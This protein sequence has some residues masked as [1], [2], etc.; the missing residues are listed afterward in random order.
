[1]IMKHLTIVLLFLFTIKTLTAQNSKNES[2]IFD[3]LNIPDY[4]V[5]SLDIYAATINN[6]TSYEEHKY[7]SIGNNKHELDSKI[8]YTFF[9][10]YCL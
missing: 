2:I 4:K 7:G 3:V 10:N 1:M 5:S 9:Y 6:I 8:K